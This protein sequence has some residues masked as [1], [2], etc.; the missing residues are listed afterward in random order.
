MRGYCCDSRSMTTET[1]AAATG[2]SEIRNSPVVGSARNSISFTPCLS[3]SKIVV[4]RLMSA[5]P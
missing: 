5:R 1:I 4:P 2:S 3:S